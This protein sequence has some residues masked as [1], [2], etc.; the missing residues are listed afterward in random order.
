MMRLM[1]KQKIRD[2][3]RR[4]P[5]IL[6][7]TL[8]AVALVVLSIFIREQDQPRDEPATPSPEATPSLAPTPSPYAT[9]ELSFARGYRGDGWELY[10]TEPGESRELEAYSGGIDSRLAG[11]IDAAQ[12]SLDMAVF[13]LS[14]QAIIEAIAAA[15]ERGISTRLVVDDEYGL[16]ADDAPLQ[17]LADAGVAIVDD[18]RSG[19]M[20]NKFAIIDGESVW[21]GSWNYSINGAYKHNNNA[22]VLHDADVASAYQAEFNEMFE[23]GEF[24]KRSTDQGVVSLV[25][26]GRE[27]D[28]VFA[29]EAEELEWMLREIQNAR[30]SVRFL[31]FAFSLEELSA[32]MIDANAKPGVSV[33]G[34]F[35]VWQGS[36]SWSQ[37]PALHC[38][39]VEVREDGNRDLLHHKLLIIDDEVVITGSFNFSRSAAETNDENIIILRDPVIG[40]LYGDEFRRVWD[41]AN[42]IRPDEI[43]CD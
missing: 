9:L 21:T 20:H 40:A 5:L 4:F 38:A 35:D 13:Q 41:V 43:Q 27:I 16:H 12:E 24:G 17:G 29:P 18:D 2:R 15:H 25:R 37:L 31:I 7:A 19:R 1:Q 10:F 42:A 11:A 22:I 34:V 33:S 14:S 30:E 26:A 8:A 39:G 6:L 36:A 32:A 3:S 23:A 28:I